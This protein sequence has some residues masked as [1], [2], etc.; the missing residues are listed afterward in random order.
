M[1]PLLSSRDPGLQVILGN[2]VPCL[3]GL[4]CGI[5][6]GISEPAYLI[7]SLLGVLGGY[8]AGLEH[9]DAPEGA[10]RGIVGGAQ[11]GIFILL[12]K[13][14]SG[15]DPKADLPDPQVLLVVLT[16]VIGAGLGALG[17]RRRGKRLEAEGV[18]NVVEGSGLSRSSGG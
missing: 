9:R 4:I 15:M 11:F 8:V 17:G 2:I 10:M 14:I 13:E 12:G 18:L 5:V 16:T 1:P 3:F 6:L 7:L